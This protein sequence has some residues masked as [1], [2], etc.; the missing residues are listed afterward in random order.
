MIIKKKKQEN[1]IL[2]IE[3]ILKDYFAV[4]NK[5][6]RVENIPVYVYDIVV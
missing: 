4:N 3:P 2:R 5:V 6:A 1:I